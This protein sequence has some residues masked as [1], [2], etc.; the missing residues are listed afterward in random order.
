MFTIRTPRNLFFI[1]LFLITLLIFS[2][3]TGCSP[4]HGPKLFEVTTEQDVPDR[5][6][7]PSGNLQDDLIRDP[8][9]VKGVLPNGFGYVILKNRTPQDRVSMHLQVMAGSMHEEENQRGVAH[10]LE[11][12]LFNGSTNFKPGELI[13][14]FQSIGMMFGP[15]AN[16]RT[17]FFETVYDILLPRGDRESLEKGL[18]VFKDYCEGALLL[19]SEVERER[20]VILAEKRDRDS[21]SF[22]TFKASLEFEL[23]DSRIARRLPIGVEQVIKAA[24]SE[25]LRTYYDTWYRPD[26][27]MMIIVGDV[28]PDT[29]REMIRETFSAMEPRAAPGEMP[30][31]EWV[32]HDGDK[33]FYHHE[34]EAG[35][36]R[37]SIGTVSRVPFGSETEDDLKNRV[38]ERLADMIVNNRLSKDMQDDDPPFSGSAIYSGVFL[39]N[40]RFTSISAQGLPDKWPGALNH[41]ERRLRQALSHGFTSREI[42]RVKADF[43]LGLESAARE[44]STRKSSSLA[45][46]IISSISRK[47]LFLSPIQELELLK[48][49]VESLTMDDIHGA[50]KSSWDHPHRLIQVTGNALVTQRINTGTDELFSSDTS[51]LSENEI[52]D[53]DQN[54]S[55]AWVNE[56]AEAVILDTYY[57][58]LASEVPP[59]LNE[60]TPAFPYLPRPSPADAPPVDASS[61]DASPVDASSAD[62]SPVDASSADPSPVDASPADASPAD[63]FDNSSGELPDP[64]FSAYIQRDVVLEDLGIRVVE[65]KNGIRLNIKQNDYKKGEFL[66][67]LAFGQGKSLEPLDKP[68]LALVSGAVINGSGVGALNQDELNAALAGRDVSTKFNVDHDSFS[69]SG[70]ASSDETELLFQLLYTRIVDPAFRPQALMLFRDR[71]EQMSREFTRTPDAMMSYLGE[72]FLAGGD[73]RFGMPSLD[74]VNAVELHDVK[75]W[76]MPAL[77]GSELEISVA[78]DVDM[79]KTVAAAVKWFAPLHRNL[80]GSTH[81]SGV[82]VED[83]TSKASGGRNTPESGIPGKGSGKRPLPKFPAGESIELALDT[84]LDKALVVMAFGT[85]DFWDMPKTRRLNILA[86][87]FSEELR[88]TLREKMGAT[89]SPYAYNQG[90]LAYE[91]YGVLRGVV[92]VSPGMTEDV[93]TYM[94]EIAESLSGGGI[95]PRDLE[96]V[97]EPVLT[98]LKD[99]VKTNGYWLNSVLSGSGD[100]PEKFEWARS[101]MDDYGSISVEDV[102]KLADEFMKPSKGA[103][104]I[105]KPSL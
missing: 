8:D 95:S 77:Q 37:V 1:N 32:S 55:E 100:H 11:H 81:G 17:G 73:S 34:P 71:Y 84:R 89:Y 10:F 96:L 6:T 24:D 61:A 91:G 42:T 104:I 27:M 102:S 54:V 80:R 23:P 87:I 94:E 72:N 29:A 66:F 78:G 48:P 65:F 50:F 62:A 97:L 16:A 57:E 64:R 35:S 31:N 93:L 85:D 63:A 28:D 105:I 12:M 36:T 51:Y 18:L 79:A 20:G 39:Q 83:T 92:G 33:A 59:P 56:T 49:F 69:F 43:L 13:K 88:K 30:E 47:R 19:E 38:V 25:L 2:L 68:G 82:S 67:N 86:K 9:V 53:M 5:R 45:R 46:E 70:S 98:Y 52:N 15:D 90:S 21:V 58:S 40:V 74:M 101:I 76:L 22:R 99:M 41:I 3:F 103:R 60:D 75:E 14:Y 7:A 44:A 4:G 26:N